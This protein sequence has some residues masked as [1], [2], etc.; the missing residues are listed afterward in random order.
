MMTDT[1]S[2]QSCLL[3]LE[4]DDH[5]QS[6]METTEVDYL[7]FCRDMNASKCQTYNFDS[8]FDMM[9][10]RHSLFLT[11]WKYAA[12]TV[13]LLKDISLQVHVGTEDQGRFYDQVVVI[14]RAFIEH[15]EPRVQ[16]LC[17][18]LMKNVLQM[19]W[20][21]I[22]MNLYRDLVIPILEKIRNELFHRR[23]TFRSTNLGDEQIIPLDDLTGWRSL[24]NSLILLHLLIIGVGKIHRQ[25]ELCFQGNQDTY[26][27]VASMETWLSLEDINL[28]VEKASQHQNRYVR[29][30]TLKFLGELI[31]VVVEGKGSNIV[32]V[33]REEMLLECDDRQHEALSYTT[34]LLRKI[35]KAL[36]VGLDD[37]WSQNKL[38]AIHSTRSFLLTFDDSTRSIF[39]P[40]FLP[41]I[42]MNRFYVAEGIRSYSSELWFELMGPPAMGRGKREVS[43]LLPQFVEHYCFMCTAKNHMIVEA[44][45]QAVNELLIRIEKE[46]LQGLI[47]RISQT[48]ITSLQQDSWPIRDAA[49]LSSGY[50]VRYYP[51][52]VE[53]HLS[54]IVNVWKTQLK[55]PIWSVRENAATAFGEAMIPT[56]C[57]CSQSNCRND[58]LKASDCGK[59]CSICHVKETVL[60]EAIQYLNT[61]LLNA[62]YE[63]EKTS[64]FNFLPIAMMNS[65]SKEKKV[66]VDK[67]LSKPLRSSGWGC[68][69][70]CLSPRSSRPW[71]VSAGCILLFRELVKF[72]A[73]ARSL[74]YFTQEKI[75][76]LRDAV[77]LNWLRCWILLDY[78]FDD[79]EKLRFIVLEQVNES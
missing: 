67:A 63:T 47:S 55:D 39:F 24:E 49:C 54:V 33:V 70:D 78:E 28:V 13:L 65:Q 51:E 58:A 64:T 37:E 21:V 71:E 50:L 8:I 20:D 14:V 66:I 16:L 46:M 36:C 59:R 75:D 27:H 60:L 76:T 7:E 77:K 74:P 19:N 41:R 72:L 57:D 23:A 10:C 1:T 68:C 45:L 48:V 40:L 26:E 6:E 31:A 15:N 2:L 34:L 32:Q 38:V 30:H 35:S 3:S 43:G 42:A 4:K 25:T 12:L 61:M 79:K 22:R 53:A 56:P 18:D 69:L 29:E 73:V 52:Q 17:I 44:A 9:R 5:S 62:T 11:N